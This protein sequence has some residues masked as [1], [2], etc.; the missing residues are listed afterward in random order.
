MTLEEFCRHLCSTTTDGASVMI[1]YL[2]GVATKLQALTPGKVM[3]KYWCNCHKLELCFKDAMKDVPLYKNHVHYVAQKCFYFYSKKQPLN[4]AN[5]EAAS[6]CIC[7][8]I[9]KLKSVET[10]GELSN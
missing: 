3:K 7:T 9:Q 8:E 2:S 1:G 4:R 6:Q 5:L 10:R